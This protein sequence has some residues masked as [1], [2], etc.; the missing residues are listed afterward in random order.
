MWGVDLII[1]PSLDRVNGWDA[2]HGSR[3]TGRRGTPMKVNAGIRDSMERIERD[4]PD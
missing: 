1:S 2:S 4:I 3:I